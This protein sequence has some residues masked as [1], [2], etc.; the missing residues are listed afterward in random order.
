V[1]AVGSGAVVVGRAPHWALVLLF[2][3]FVQLIMGCERFRA[4]VSPLGWERS[5]MP[6]QHWPATDLEE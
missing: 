4:G 2:Q 3:Q 1:G 5:E 6:T